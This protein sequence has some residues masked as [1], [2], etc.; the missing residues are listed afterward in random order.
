MGLAFSCGWY[1]IGAPGCFPWIYHK[2]C[3]AL[4]ILVYTRSR[5]CMCMFFED[6]LFNPF[7]VAFFSDEEEDDEMTDDD[8]GSDEFEDEEEGEEEEEDGDDY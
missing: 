8:F 3:N 1:K 6:T 2:L 4:L 7:W 5:A